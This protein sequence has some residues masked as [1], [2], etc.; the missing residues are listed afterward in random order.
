MEM[1]SVLG[2]LI[3]IDN[4][5]GF[6]LDGIVY[7]EDSARTTVVHIHGSFGNFYQG[8]LVRV[9]AMM[10]RDSGINLLSVNLA[11]HDGLAEGYRSEDK[12]EYA[13]GAVTDFNECTTDIAGAVQFAKDF[14]DRVILQGHSLGCDRILEYSI[15]NNAPYD[16]VLL[17]PCDSYQLQANWIAPETV[18][19]QIQRL[20]LEAPGDPDFD[21]LPSR[22]YG[23]KGGGDWTYSIPVTRKAF[24]TIAEGAPYRL[25]RIS[26]GVPFRLNQRAFIYIGGLD[27]LQVWPNRVMFD[28]L[29]SRINEM[30]EVY[31]DQGDHNLSGCEEAVT[32]RIIQWASRDI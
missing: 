13:G 11:S 25:M 12:F 15:K 9:M 31:I 5:C 20:K 26:S 17:S 4:G 22:E 27:A 28:Y 18:E 19:E 6:Q 3:T 24:L 30:E 21:W 10:Y 2:E 14:S 23:V 16:L 8:R 1:R 29:R 7:R 32:Q